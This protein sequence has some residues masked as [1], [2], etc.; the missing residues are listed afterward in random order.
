MSGF[1]R[2]MQWTA[3]VVLALMIGV[4]AGPA[5][6]QTKR[7]SKRESSANRKARMERMAEDTYSHRYEMFGGGGY[8]R[9]RSGEYLQKNN[10]IV[11]ATSA[12]YYL[13]PKLGI[14]GDIR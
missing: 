13:N 7:R 3:A 1:G 8:L 6:A 9:F 14:I 2:K 12:A 4:W 10:E 11:W 5:G